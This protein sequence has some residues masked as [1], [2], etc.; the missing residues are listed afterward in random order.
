[1]AFSSAPY[2]QLTTS[3]TP[4]STASPSLILSS[5]SG[6]WGTDGCT[7]E[8]LVLLLLGSLVARHESGQVVWVPP[9]GLCVN[10]FEEV[11]QETKVSR[12]FSNTKL[13]SF[14]RLFCSLFPDC[15][16]SKL[17]AVLVS[18]LP[19]SR[20]YR[21]VLCTEVPCPPGDSQCPYLGTSLASENAG[22]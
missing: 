9:P 17:W 18:Y 22:G 19:I 15:P 11:G 14:L 7:F 4:P 10:A 16:I 6:T 5:S 12:H 8:F 20:G 2:H 13:K 21:E 3:P 1:M